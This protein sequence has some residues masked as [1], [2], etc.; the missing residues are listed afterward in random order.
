MYET[1][2]NL[3]KNKSDNIGDCM[4]SKNKE[5]YYRETISFI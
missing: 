3:L 1:E 4:E 2:N 5:N